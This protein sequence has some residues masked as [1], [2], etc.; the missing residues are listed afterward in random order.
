MARCWCAKA[1]C[2]SSST[3]PQNGAT[4]ARPSA[5]QQTTPFSGALPTGTTCAPP[6]V[7]TVPAGQASIAVSVASTPVAS[8]DI[9]IN[10]RFGL[11]VV[12]NQDTGVGQEALAYQPTGGVPAGQYSVEICPSGNP[13][14]PLVAPYSYSGTFTTDDTA[15]PEPVPYPPKWRFF[16]SNP[17]ESYASADTRILGCW[18]TTVNGQPVPGCD[19]A[20]KN[21][22]ARATWDFSVK[23]NKPTNT[24]IGN[25]ATTARS[26]ELPLTPSEQYRPVSAARSYDYPWT[27][28][29]HTEKCA[30][31]VFTSP[32]ANDS[33]AA[34]TN[35][36]AVHNRMHDWSYRLGF[37]EQNYNAQDSNFGNSSVDAENDAEVGNV[38]AGAVDGGA[39]G[40]YMGRDNANQ[41]TLQDGTPPITNMYLWQPIAAAFYPECVDGDYDMSV[42]G[43]E[44]THL[45]SNRM[46]GGPDASLSGN[47]AG[48]MGES[49]SDLSATEYLNEYGFVP[50]S[51]DPNNRYVVGRYVTGNQQTGIR[52]FVMSANPL[53]Y[54]NFGYD[55]ACNSD[56]VTSECTAQSEFH[57]DAEIWDAVNFAMRQA[58]ITKYNAQAPANDAALQV[59][60]ADGARSLLECPGNRRW[61]QIMFDAF[62]LMPPD[63]TF[64][65][66]RDAYLAADRLRFNGA[67][68]AELWQAFG[69]HGM[70]QFASTSGSED[71]D[72][73]A[74]FELPLVT[75]EPTIT[76]QA[77][78]PDEGSRAVDAKIFVGRFEARGTPIADTNPATPVVVGPPTAPVT[79]TQITASAKFVPG[80]YEFVAQAPGYGLYR[81]SRTFIA[82]QNQTVVV[83]MPT[84]WASLTKGG[85]VTTTVA[86]DQ[87]FNLESLIDDTENTTWARRASAA[88]G[89]TETITGTEA[90]VDLG[91]AGHRVTR[92]Q[93][94]AMQRLRN[95]T[96]S[97]DPAGQSR[98]SALRQFEILDL[99]PRGQ[100]QLQRRNELYPHL[101]Q[102][103]RCV[104]RPA[105]A[106]DRARA[107]HALVR[108]AG[109]RCHP[110]QAAGAQLTVH[111][112]PGLPGRPRQ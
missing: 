25:A 63:V 48:A 41:I 36:F 2:S 53:T 56:T 98:F 50:Q 97:A 91:G 37:T 61:I 45:I 22:A 9:E 39:A 65:S 58:L 89:S 80:T 23:Q 11:T 34:V 5:A 112:R 59:A 92:V 4:A 13:V 66:A 72:P 51:S 87:N 107:D 109:D 85:T 64:L 74:N 10:L 31:T 84:N 19:L 82:G 54:G 24:T 32:Q 7:F 38:Q 47:Q 21:L 94:S 33:D 102:P 16:T 15:A 42:I 68:Q 46:V 88:T 90:I 18:E 83:A 99:Q 60:C 69:S 57:S 40:Q 71:T 30:P 104:P 78:A 86:L 28:Q 67:N 111:R 73:V 110:C 8:N 62:L 108:R 100:G 93:V 1:A 14:A 26:W 17:A 43:H 96:N 44:Y 81:F 77:V 35:L 79:L 49:W 6:H 103:G 70:G 75:T 3:A 106:A 105:A 27:N 20:L 95:G 12:A 52:N 76:F 101:H 55:L 29:W